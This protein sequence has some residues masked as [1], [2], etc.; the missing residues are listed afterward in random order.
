M[1]EVKFRPTPQDL[2]EGSRAMKSPWWHKWLFLL[3]LCLMFLVG[4]FLVDHGF[5]LAG[6]LWLV[7][8]VAI[9]IGVYR[10]PTIWAKHRLK[11]D[12]LFQA[13][14]TLRLDECG[15]ESEYA[16]GR[17]RLEWEGVTGYKENTKSFLVF[18]SEYHC[19]L[20]PKA[21]MSSAQIEELRKLLRA[22][23]SVSTSR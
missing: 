4:V 5:E 11:H 12:Q 16:H 9:A 23:I 1:V 2:V 15:I 17:S 21:A 13:E 19:T 18:A 3:L 22:H 7:I 10:T 14:I 6:W 20:I 8:S